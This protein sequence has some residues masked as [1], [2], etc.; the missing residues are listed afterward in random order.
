MG[1]LSGIGKLESK[2]RMFFD[3]AKEQD[4][5]ISEIIVFYKG[6]KGRHISKILK[7]MQEFYF[8]FPT[9]VDSFILINGKEIRGEA[10]I[11]IFL[12]DLRRDDRALSNS[13]LKLIEP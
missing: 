5:S 13:L 10:N 7:Q 3:L 2:S 12:E 6:P 11:E 4:C 9:D 8:E 1:N